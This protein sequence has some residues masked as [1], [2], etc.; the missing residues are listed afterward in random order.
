MPRLVALLPEDGWAFVRDGES[1]VVVH[2]P[3]RTVD[4]R[5]APEP[6]VADAVLHHGFLDVAAASPDETWPEVIRRIRDA[7]R[8][9]VGDPAVRGSFVNR[10]LGVVPMAMITA[11]LDDLERDWIPHKLA[12]AEAVLHRL[13]SEERVWAD[14]M[15]HV[16]VI[17][18][19]EAVARARQAQAEDRRIAF[20]HP[21]LRRLRQDQRFVRR[22]APFRGDGPGLFG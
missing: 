8:H 21:R 9:A 11:I 7:M 20:A 1:L 18:L 12:P 19:L 14:R 5:V 2:P 13:L 3:F 15:I 6:V 22:S 4:R 16:R 17:K 10:A